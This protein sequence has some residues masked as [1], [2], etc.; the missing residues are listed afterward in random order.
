M[1]TNEMINVAVYEKGRADALNLQSR[2]DNMNGTELYA[3]DNVIP[4]FV[5]ACKVMNMLE[6]PIGFVCKSSAGRIVKLIQ[7]YDSTTFTA[8]PEEL[9]AQWGFKWSTDPAKAL[10][11]VAISTSPYM[12][13]DCCI[14]NG[15]IYRS[16][17]DNNVFAPSGYSLGWEAVSNI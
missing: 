11:F 17:T 15:I 2:A 9:S 5:E 1:M 4:T 16:L 14:E 3:E 13:N 8:E 12:I 7:P 10:E 6:R